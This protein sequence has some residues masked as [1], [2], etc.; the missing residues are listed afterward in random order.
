MHILQVWCPSLLSGSHG[1]SARK[2]SLQSTTNL[3]N[4]TLSN[5]NLGEDRQAW[6]WNSPSLSDQGG[7][8]ASTSNC[9]HP[10][11]PLQLAALEEGM[12]GEQEL[13]PTT[14]H[15]SQLRTEMSS[16]RET[17]GNPVLLIS[18]FRKDDPNRLQLGTCDE[19]VWARAC[20]AKLL[21]EQGAKQ[22]D[23]NTACSTT[24]CR[25]T[26]EQS[27]LTRQDCQKVSLG[28]IFSKKI[29]SKQ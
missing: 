5:K 27:S 8:P 29:R 4:L 1:D 3:G 10:P 20:K 14:T 16:L 25:Q 13:L 12:G 26:K 9:S 7:A 21:K 6:S 17:A 19:H 18:S 15:L 11:S 22:E 2:P 24:A 28:E 23:P